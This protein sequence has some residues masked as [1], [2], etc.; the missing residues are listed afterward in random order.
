MFLLEV[1]GCKSYKVLSEPERAQGNT[2]QNNSRC[3]DS[4]LAPGWYRFQGA[5]GDRIADKCV[6]VDRC[7]TQSPGWLSGAHPTVAECVVTRKVCY[8]WSK[9]CCHRSNNITVKNCGSYYVYELY[10]TPGCYLRYCGNAGATPTSSP[11]SSSSITTKEVKKKFMVSLST[12]DVLQATSLQEAVILFK[13]TTEKYKKMLFQQVQFNATAEQEQKESI[14]QTAVAFEKF[15]L[16]YSHYHLNESRPQINI[17]SSSLVLRIQRGFPQNTSDFLLEVPGSKYSIKVSS[18]NFDNSETVV[19]GIVYK[20]FHELLITN[21]SKND[22]IDNTR[23]LNTMIMAATMDPKPKTL[24]ENVALKFK[25]LTVADGKRFCVFWNGF[26][27]EKS[28]DGWSGEGC[29][30]KSTSNAK[31]TECSCNHM[32]HFAVL[33]DYSESQEI[34]KTDEKILR[35]LTYVGLALSITGETLTIIS[36]VLLTDVHQPLSQIRMSLAGSLGV[37]Q[38]IFLVGINA[39]K[40]TGACVT[41]AAL[42]QYFLMTAFCWMLVEGIYFYL[43]VVKVYNINNKM[44]IYHLMSWGIPAVMVAM[45]L[46]IAAGKDGIQSFIDDEYCWM[47]SD[48]NLIWIFAA[49]VV[50]IETVNLLILVRVVKEMRTM[51]P[52]E[53]NLSHQIRVGIKAC[54]V[55]SPL[56]GIT[57]LFGLLSPLHKAFVYIFTVLNSIQ[58]FLIFLLHCA[59]NSQLKDRFKRKLNT[60]FPTANDGN[61]ARKTSKSEEKSEEQRRSEEGLPNFKLNFCDQLE[62]ENFPDVAGL[63]Q[64]EQDSSQELESFISAEKSANTIK[65]TK[66]E[67]KRFENYSQ[68]QTDGTFHIETVPA[69]VLDKLL[70]KFFKDVR[71][72]DGAR[73][74]HFYESAAPST[75]KEDTT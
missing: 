66:S 23:R 4:N 73:W 51:Q 12:I 14:F 33:F 8:H 61:P 60:V 47:S 48:N 67:W 55:M 42:L 68:E 20:D 22:G 35:I 21:H 3:G 26:N 32:T 62:E 17:F 71:K 30:A 74:S 25:H 34:T 72:R 39:S 5:A 59:K 49:F 31:E 41:V 24:L 29:H 11:S 56:L 40:N 15:V 54:A 7:G 75:S 10:E 37:G 65:K 70:G 43:F 52:T 44:A 53:D 46:S 27:G 2:E 50:V 9:R 28:P 18:R 58:G 16:N 6:P 36:Y 13:N 38:I 45:S 63:V 69:D 64:P 19:V 57:W 1:D